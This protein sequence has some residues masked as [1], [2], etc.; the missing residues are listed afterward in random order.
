[1]DIVLSE[2]QEMLKRSARELLRGECS[3]DLVRAMESDERGYPPQPWQR[4]AQLGWLGLPFPQRYGGGDGSFF[5]LALLVEELGYAAAPTPFLS[6]TLLGGLVLLE[7][8]T[9][10]QKRSLLPGVAS[11]ELLLSLAYLNGDGDLDDIGAGAAAEPRGDG[12]VLHGVK[13]GEAARG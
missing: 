10:N 1:M 4:M 8:G 11:G 2:G 13:Q 9:A 7:A 6:S 12:F 3:S 5:D